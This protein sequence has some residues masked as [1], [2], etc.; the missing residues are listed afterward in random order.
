MTTRRVRRR[1]HDWRTSGA[2]PLGKAGLAA[3]GVLYIVLGLL[4][5]QFARGYDVELERDAAG[6]VR[7]RRRPAVRHVPHQSALIVGLVALVVLGT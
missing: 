1:E 6:R 3:Q 4:A 7:G 2:T 5:I